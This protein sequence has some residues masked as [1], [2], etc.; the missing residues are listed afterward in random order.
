MYRFSAL[1]AFLTATLSCGVN[2]MPLPPD[3]QYVTAADA[4]PGAP[5]TQVE[6]PSDDAE[7]QAA[8]IRRV[9]AACLANNKHVMERGFISA[10]QYQWVELAFGTIASKTGT[11]TGYPT[12]AG[13]VD[14]ILVDIPD[15]EIGSILL[16]DV[17]A[18]V[19]SATSIGNTGII[20]ARVIEDVGGADTAINVVGSFGEWDADDVKRK[21]SLTAR[22]T[23]TTAG[24]ARVRLR[25][26]GPDI[27]LDSSI[28]GYLTIRV[29]HVRS[30]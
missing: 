24:P 10:N 22:H 2:D 29:Q 21:E 26:A 17:S 15:C 14:P 23:I 13:G 16:I 27:G 12:E 8:D 9:C 30:F 25:L 28:V 4:G 6:C 19:K 20:G 18:Y 5:F 7:A 1:L 3:H 11:G